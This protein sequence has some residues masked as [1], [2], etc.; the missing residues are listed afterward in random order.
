MTA[1]PPFPMLLRRANPRRQTR[2]LARMVVVVAS[3]ALTLSPAGLRAQ[4]LGG[5]F[6]RS[7]YRPAVLSIA[8]NEDTSSGSEAA[9]RV[10]LDL[11]LVS[12]E[13]QAVTRRVQISRDQFAATL[14]DLYQQL[15]A[16]APLSPQDPAAPVRRLHDA[17]IAPI[18]PVLREQGITT[19]LIAADRGLQA[20]PFAALHDGNTYF[21]QRYAFS[22]SPA[23]RYTALTPPQPSSGRLLAA[24]AEVF[25]GL[26]PLPLVPQEIDGLARERPADV[27]LNRAFTPGVLLEKASDPRYDRVHVATHAE[28]LPGGP[29]EARVYTGTGSIPLS[30]FVQ[31]R[32]RREGQPLDLFILSACRTAVGDKDSELGFAG[33]ALQAGSRSAVGSLW[34]VDDVATS[35]F[36]VQF[37][38]YMDQG[39]PKA[40]AIQ[41]TRRDLIQGSIRLEGNRVMGSG[42]VP[43]LTNLTLAQQQRIRTGLSHPFFWAGITLLGSPW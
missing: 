11:T 23:L 3:A 16:Q 35:A 4:A 24:G 21:G 25:P 12:T 27:F 43:L 14:R 39:Y 22:I 37:Y 5:A 1:F 26:T 31:M 28:F 32:A 38:R 2:S 42:Q 6:D 10:F 15:A 13:P 33:L 8:F 36:F 40:E 17:M 18:E 41:A 34:Y 20:L 19:L 29:Q 9:P 7:A 30:D